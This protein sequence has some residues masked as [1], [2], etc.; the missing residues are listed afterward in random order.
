MATPY[1]AGEVDTRT[2]ATRFKYGRRL[3]FCHTK[4]RNVVSV[5]L[6]LQLVLRHK[7][8]PSSPVIQFFVARH[9]QKARR[10][11]LPSSPSFSLDGRSDDSVTIIARFLVLGKTLS[12]VG[13]HVRHTV[14]SETEEMRGAVDLSAKSW[15]SSA[16]T[17]RQS[18]L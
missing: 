11:E 4:A 7:M 5:L 9:R 17:H 10:S 6:L 14:D 8:P 1:Y 18:A 2:G 12:W 3:P 13:L 15:N 16:R